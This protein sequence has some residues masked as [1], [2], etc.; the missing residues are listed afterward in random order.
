MNTPR[1][2]L[3]ISLL[4]LSA[5]AAPVPGTETEPGF[6]E[7]LPEG[8]AET[9]APGQNLQAVRITPEDGCYWYQH[10]GP[11]ETTML[12]LLSRSGGLICSRPT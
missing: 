11:V 9:A 12:P 1:S 10:V 5:C 8:L 2:L 4:A 3:A 7:E 6:F